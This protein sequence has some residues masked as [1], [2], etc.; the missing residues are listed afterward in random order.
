MRR[1][2]IPALLATACAGILAFA[3]TAAGDSRD[4]AFT[5]GVVPAGAVAVLNPGE[6]ACQS[7]ISVPAEFDG[8]R[9]QVGTYG[10]PG[11]PLAIAIRSLES[12][13]RLAGGR[14]SGGYP[15]VS[16]LSVA[17]GQ[18]RASQRVEVCVRNVGARR[19]ALYGNV[20]LA[21]GETEARIGARRLGTDLSLVFER[22]EPRSLLSLVPDI[23]ERASVFRPVWVGA[24]TFWILAGALLAGVPV[25]LALALARVPGADETSAGRSG[26]EV[27]AGRADVPHMPARAP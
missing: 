13:R 6:A 27:T 7:P 19:A 25:L 26:D 17:V 3:V 1:A 5:L 11:P 23:F 2:G 9:F 22:D 4:V 12:D 18:V 24:W 20:G 8:V 16:Q 14:L 21:A 10:K 15:D